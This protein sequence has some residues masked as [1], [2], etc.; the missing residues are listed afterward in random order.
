VVDWVRFPGS[1]SNFLFKIAVSNMLAVTHNFVRII[2]VIMG[3][4][5]SVHVSS[6]TQLIFMCPINKWFDENYTS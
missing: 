6:Q 3:M 2:T 5:W 4:I 1:K